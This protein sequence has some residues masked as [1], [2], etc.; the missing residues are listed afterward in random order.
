[1]GTTTRVRPVY[2]RGELSAF[3]KL[4]WKIYAHDSNWVP[5]LI[6]EQLA[7][8]EPPRGAFHN[9]A[10]VMLFLAYQG[11]EVVGRIAAFI[12][13][14]RVAHLSRQVGGFGFFET[15]PDYSIAE[16]LLDAAVDWLWEHNI[17]EM[18]GPTCFT[19]FEYPGILIEGAEYPP[20]MMSAHSPPYYKDY[21]ISYGLERDR[22][23]F[24]WRAFLD[25]VGS[26]LQ[27][28]PK[29][30]T[31]VAWGTLVDKHIRIRKFKIENWE[32]ELQIAHRIV[33]ESLKSSPDHVPISIEDFQQIMNQA[34]LFVDPDLFLIAESY[35]QPVG[36]CCA[37]PDKNQ[38]LAQ[39]NGRL[40][41]FGWLKVRQLTKQIDII[42]IQ[43]MGILE[44]FRQNGLAAQLY[45]ETVKAAQTKG[46]TSLARNEI[47]EEDPG[48]SYI[49]NQLGAQRYKRYWLFKFVL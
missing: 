5:P 42:T 39:L 34:R 21:L 19:E 28:L 24:T 23:F 27:S 9:H 22:E 1:M 47:P 46:Y 37:V 10:E 41:P 7:R 26:A 8:L 36:I 6:S 32:T 38:L 31:Q 29:D 35:G 13:H 45:L 12:D 20:V 2:T 48:V 25:Q 44:E 43:F 11:R 18:V 15:L 30:S 3:V 40:F 17:A 33:N 49:R 4:P 16:A 14:R